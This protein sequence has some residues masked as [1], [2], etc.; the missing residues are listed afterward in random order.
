M[1][2]FESSGEFKTEECDTNYSSADEDSFFMATQSI[3]RPNIDDLP[4]PIFNS[5]GNSLTVSDEDSS[6]GHIINS[7]SDGYDDSLIGRQYYAATPEQSMSWHRKDHHGNVDVEPKSIMRPDTQPVMQPVTQPDIQP[8]IKPVTTQP[9]IQP[10]MRPIS[11]S[12]YK[13]SDCQKL[14]KDD[15]RSSHQNDQP[16]AQS[17][18]SSGRQENS[19]TGKMEDD[20]PSSVLYELPAESADGFT[21]VLQMDA[22]KEKWMKAISMPTSDNW[23]CDFCTF[24]NSNSNTVC[25]MCGIKCKQK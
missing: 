6:M 18:V 10:V 22:N 4:E 3:P 7:R 16:Q 23:I 25:D 11:Q 2:A 14:L 17:I 12:V 5:G 20:Q 19:Q 13:G 9:N 8:D 21:V 24:I 15:D 1:Q